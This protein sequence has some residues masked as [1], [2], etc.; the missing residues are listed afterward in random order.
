M[1]FDSET[2]DTSGPDFSLA[3]PCLGVEDCKKL[4]V[5]EASWIVMRGSA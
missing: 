1:Y 2:W 3:E 4:F 5:P